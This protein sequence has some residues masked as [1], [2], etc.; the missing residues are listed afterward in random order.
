MGILGDEYEGRQVIIWSGH[1]S[2]GTIKQYVKRL[3]EKKKREMSG[4]LASNILPKKVKENETEA[5]ENAPEPIDDNNKVNFDL[6]FNLEELDDAPDDD[7]LNKF[8][9]NFEANLNNN[10]APALQANQNNAVAINVPV[11]PA[12]N[13]QNMNVQNMQNNPNPFMPAM[14]F[15]GSNVTINY[16]FGK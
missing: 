8:L 5:K 3:P 16:N 1:A 15:T 4:T 2:E 6:Q 10:Q 14:Y 11:P 9:D 7:A 13:Q 12:L